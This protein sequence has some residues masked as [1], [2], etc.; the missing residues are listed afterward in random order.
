MF[1]IHTFITRCL[2]RT[3]HKQCSYVH[4]ECRH[5]GETD[6]VSSFTTLFISSREETSMVIFPFLLDQAHITLAEK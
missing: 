3:K 4:K 2:R 5:R 6:L 1:P